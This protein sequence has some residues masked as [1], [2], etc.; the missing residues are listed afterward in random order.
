MIKLLQFEL[1]KLR[2]QKSLY[3]CSAII[4]AGL[5]LSV[6]ASFVLTRTLG[7]LDGLFEEEIPVPTAVDMVLSAVSAADFTLIAGIFIALYVCGDYS[8]KTIKNIYSRGFSRSDVYFAKLIICVGYVVIMY[9]ITELFALAVGSAFFGFEPQ[10]GNI[11]WL[12]LGQLFVC[13]ASASF[14]YAI[15]NII[16]KT[17]V[18]LAI[19]I[20]VPVALT[21]ILTLVDTVIKVYMADIIKIENFAL[22]DYWLDG[23]LMVLADAKA[24]VTKIVVS[25]I[26][27][28]IYAALFLTAGYLVNRNTE[29]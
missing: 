18:V 11:F 1:F 22:S 13:I 21:V 28:V 5:F 17:G 19:V 14:C 16:K 9:I 29:V 4:L 12:L 20:L 24:S 25:C 8:Q 7:G 27:P 26:L 10:G 15:A 23:M 2:K 6:A 3:I